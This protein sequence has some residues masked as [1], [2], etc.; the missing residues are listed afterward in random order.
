MPIQ[1]KKWRCWD[2]YLPTPPGSEP[3]PVTA[4]VPF[5]A[6]ETYSIEQSG[7]GPHWGFR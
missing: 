4:A 6:E 2:S 7:E 1:K 5:Q 3:N